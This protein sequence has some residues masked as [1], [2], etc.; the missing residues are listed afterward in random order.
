MKDACSLSLDTFN[1]KEANVQAT[2]DFFVTKKQ[3][4]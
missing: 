3:T 4:L 2:T 1:E